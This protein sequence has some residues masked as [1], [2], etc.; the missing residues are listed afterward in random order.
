MPGSGNETHEGQ[1]AHP[2]APIELQVEYKKLNTFFS[3]Y[4]KN[5]SKGGTFIKTERPLQ[6]GTEFVFRLVIPHMEDHVQLRGCVAWV[7]SEDESQRPDVRENGMGIR[8]IYEDDAKRDMF[9]QL[10]EELMK[11][12]LGPVVFDKLM[13]RAK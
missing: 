3:D 12:S 8:F 2:R 11:N 10:V 7:N 1:R 5:I 6:V 9:E 4:T 13:A